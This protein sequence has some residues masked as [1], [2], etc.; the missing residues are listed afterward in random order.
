[1][2]V[3]DRIKRI[4]NL[5]GLAQKELGTAVGFDEKAADARIAQ[6]ESGTRTAERGYATEHFGST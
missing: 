1:M 6:Y 3:G 5:R 2:A 4:R